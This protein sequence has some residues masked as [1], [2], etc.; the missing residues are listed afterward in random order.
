MNGE[1]LAKSDYFASAWKS[2]GGV[3]AVLSKSGYPALPVLLHVGYWHP[4]TSAAVFLKK[5]IDDAKTL[6]P[7]DP[8]AVRASMKGEDKEILS[9]H[10]LSA[11]SEQN[12]DFE[13]IIED[14][15][16]R[17]IELSS[18]GE[19]SAAKVLAD[20]YGVPVRTMHTRLRLARERKLLNSPGSGERL[21][22]S[23]E[24]ALKKLLK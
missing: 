9:L 7:L 5:L 23:Y 6:E 4:T 1:F 24:A 21:G 19:S 2:S 18:W 12:R 13:S 15:A 3:I 11:Q 16:W 22:S 17:Y 20:D 14:V 8:L 10:L